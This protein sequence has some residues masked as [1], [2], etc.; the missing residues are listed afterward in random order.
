M[1]IE[2]VEGGFMLVAQQ[3]VGTRIAEMRHL[4]NSLTEAK[5]YGER[6]YA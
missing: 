6:Y 2:K 1:R 5:T 4:F 3:V